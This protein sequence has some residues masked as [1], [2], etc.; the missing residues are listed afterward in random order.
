[1]SCGAG[2]A[3]K[4]LQKIELELLAAKTRRLEN[5]AKC[6]RLAKECLLAIKRIDEKFEPFKTCLDCE[7][8]DRCTVWP[9]L[10]MEGVT[11]EAPIKCPYKQKGDE[12]HA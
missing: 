12:N 8:R 6:W 1:M 4:L 7:F 10:R 3:N 2:F 5:E 9:K 11:E